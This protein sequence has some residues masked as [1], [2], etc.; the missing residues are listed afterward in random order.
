MSFIS[1]LFFGRVSWD[2]IHP[3]PEPSPDDRESIEMFV[4]SFRKFADQHIDPAGIDEEKTIPGE[5][6][7]GLSELGIMGMTI[8]EEYGGF[9]ASLTAYCRI[10]EEASRRCNSVAATI[11]GHQSIGF[12]GILMRG[13]EALKKKYLPRCATGETLACYALTEPEAGSDMAALRTMARYDPEK[14][15]FVLNGTKQWITNAG[16]ADLFTLFASEEKE[17]GEKRRKITAFVVTRDMEG[18][19]S[20]KEEEKMGLKGSSTTSLLLE[21]VEVPEE[22]VIGERGEGFKIALEILNTGRLSLAANCVGAAKEMIDRSLE[23]A[24]D[25]KQFGTTIADFEM[26]RR[27]FS[28]MMTDVYIMESMVY[29]TSGLVDQGVKEYNLESAASKVFATEGVWRVIDNAVQINGGN[30]FM[31]EYPFERYMRD[32]RVKIIFEGT[33]EVLRM[34][35]PLVGLKAPHKIAREEGIEALRNSIAERFPGAAPDKLLEA[36]PEPLS[37]EAR[38]ALDLTSRF[39]E[40]VEKLVTTYGREIRERG[41][42]QE[43]AANAAIHLYALFAALSRTTTLIEK[44]GEESAKREIDLTRALAVRA[45]R[46]IRENLDQIDSHDDGRKN[47]IT[48]DLYAEKGYV[49]NFI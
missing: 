42:Q 44:K 23:F 6:I 39:Y 7:R 27:K 36:I 41:Y 13:S 34:M 18:F 37:G 10:M 32:C 47:T 2:R 9:G 25:R 29:L 28:D 26:I 19:S 24:L 43:R 33:N 48:D 4:D 14:K 49:F 38:A 35:I 3:F 31:R 20:G 11:G 1:D 15:S 12:K 17:E 16:I 45:E 46:A 22:N 21:D 8:P 5:V 30:G 40:T